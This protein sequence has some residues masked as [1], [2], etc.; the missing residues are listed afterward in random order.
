MGA[1]SLLEPLAFG[2]TASS[3]LPFEVVTLVRDPSVG[4]VMLVLA[5]ALIV[6]YLMQRRAA[7]TTLFLP[8]GNHGI[9]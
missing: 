7:F 9:R 3:L 4:G 8:G 1:S 6:V 2:G 5:N